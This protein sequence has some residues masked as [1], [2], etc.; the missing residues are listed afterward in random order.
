MLTFLLELGRDHSPIQVRW[1]GFAELRNFVFELSDADVASLFGP[2]PS[3]QGMTDLGIAELAPLFDHISSLAEA[4]DSDIRPVPP[5][6][7]EWNMLSPQVA[8]LLRAGMARE[9]LVRD[10]FRWSPDP[11]ERDR[12]GDI[13]RRRYAALKEDR[14]S[15]DDIYVALQAWLGGNQI[16]SAARQ[17]AVLAVLA[18]LF[19]ECDIFDRPP[20]AD[21]S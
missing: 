16:G 13:A 18:F 5:T 1:W 21:A 2:A 17:N 15:P 14:R 6:K 8:S 4:V 12:V 9:R 19:Q 20:V 10:Y 7:L 3:R 11:R